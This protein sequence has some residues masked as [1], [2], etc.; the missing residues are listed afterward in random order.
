MKYNIPAILFAGGKSSRMGEDK[1]L[2]AFGEE[3]SL[4][5]YQ[6]KKLK[7]L[8]HTVYLSSK[9]DKFNF[10]A[11]ILHDCYEESSPLVA[12]IS[13]FETLSCDT[14]FVLSV[15][16]PFID[17]TIIEPLI[18]QMQKDDDVCIAKSPHG[19]EPLCG[20]YKRSMLPKAKEALDAK[21]H[22]LTHLLENLQTRYVY[23][24]ESAYF[25][26]LNHPSEYQEALK[27][28]KN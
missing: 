7:K 22:K 9:G 23:F 2:L 24:E 25:S 28:V 1:A 17:A 15:D 16:A 19:I 10:S 11:P 6:Y 4:S 12:L 14:V 27:R 20:C 5:H 18:T 21:N 8:F 26:N 13:I 3:D